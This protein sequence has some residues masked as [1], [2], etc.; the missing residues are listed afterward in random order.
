VD[1]VFSKRL[2]L[3][4][5]S[6]A[7]MRCYAR[8]RR[9]DS[10]RVTARILNLHLSAFVANA[11]LGSMKLLWRYLKNWV[12][13]LNKYFVIAEKFT[14]IALGRIAPCELAIIVVLIGITHIADANAVCRS[15]LKAA[16]PDSRF[17]LN[18]NGTVSDRKTQLMWKQCAEGLTGT[19][20]SVGTAQRFTWKAAL[21][22][23]ATSSFAGFSDWRVPNVKELMSIV[24]SRCYEPAINE[25]IFPN[26][27]IQAAS[28]DTFWSSS[29]SLNVLD[30]AWHVSFGWGTVANTRIDNIY[31][32]RLVRS[33]Q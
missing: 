26:T 17:I 6:G 28:F 31:D 24:E 8:F 21:D 15:D 4:I 32:V 19:A 12:V 1:N 25:L 29:R 33:S 7:E 3:Q 2:R 30:Y 5:E 27:P 18:L 9:V 20:C 23:A 14:M 16:A 22:N 10:F 11:S 13:E